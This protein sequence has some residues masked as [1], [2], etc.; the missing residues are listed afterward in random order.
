M[1]KKYVVAMCLLCILMST[2]SYT[3][4]KAELDLSY[5]NIYGSTESEY[6]KLCCE[7]K[8]STP[9]SGAMVTLER[10]GARFL[11][12]MLTLYK[13]VSV[14]SVAVKRR[15]YAFFGK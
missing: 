5:D 14:T 15:V 3:Q 7:Q 1:K 4:K 13:T 2:N 11:D 8:V 10:Y 6:T 9:Q 12:I